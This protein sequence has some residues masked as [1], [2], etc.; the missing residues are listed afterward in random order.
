M[1]FANNFERIE[2]PSKLARHNTARGNSCTPLRINT[3]DNNTNLFSQNNH[4]GS[5]SATLSAFPLDKSSL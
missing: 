5:L 4:K 3:S 2:Q 1:V